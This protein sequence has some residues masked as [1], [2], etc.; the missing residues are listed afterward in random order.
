[1]ANA[2]KISLDTLRQNVERRL[3]DTETRCKRA[4]VLIDWQRELIQSMTQHG[5]GHVALAEEVLVSLIESHRWN[6]AQLNTLKK[7]LGFLN[8]I[9]VTVTTHH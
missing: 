4:T 3:R 2:D 5:R 1:M 7:E 9:V 8:N 6:E